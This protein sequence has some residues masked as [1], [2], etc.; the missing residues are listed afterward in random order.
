MLLEI[1]GLCEILCLSQ[2]S[3]GGANI[4]SGVPF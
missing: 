1:K 3:A 2:V 4:G